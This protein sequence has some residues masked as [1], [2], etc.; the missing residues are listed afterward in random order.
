MAFISYFT[1]LATISSLVQ[2]LY[3]YTLWRE[4]MTWQFVYGKAHE[5]NAE[6]QYQDELFGL[7]LALAYLRMYTLAAIRFYH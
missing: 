7:K 3:D 6:V 4:I 5:Q 2:Q 1:L